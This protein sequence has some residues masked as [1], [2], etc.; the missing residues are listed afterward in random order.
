MQARK[1]AEM[2][3]FEPEAEEEDVIPD[4]STQAGIDASSTTAGEGSLPEI[5]TQST[6]GQPTIEGKVRKKHLTT[7]RRQFCL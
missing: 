4:A 6:K 7:N 2:Q 5:K 1:E 3:S